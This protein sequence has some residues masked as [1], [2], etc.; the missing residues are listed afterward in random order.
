MNKTYGLAALFFG[1]VALASAAIASPESKSYDS[2]KKL[3]DEE[4]AKHSREALTVTVEK[5]ER[6]LASP[7]ALQW[8]NAKISLTV[9]SNGFKNSYSAQVNQILS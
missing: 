2:L 8:Q 9:D 1:L 6:K 4:G 3:A 7:P 5:D